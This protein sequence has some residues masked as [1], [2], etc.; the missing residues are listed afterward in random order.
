MSEKQTSTLSI[1]SM[2]SGII[3][4]FFLL[5]AIPAVVCGHLALKEI[6]KENREGRG[7][8]IAGLVTGYFGIALLTIAITMLYLLVIQKT[9]QFKDLGGAEVLQAKE[10]PR[11]QVRKPVI[12]PV[13]KPTIPPK[14]PTDVIITELKKAIRISPNHAGAYFNLGNAYREQDQHDLAIESYK[15]AISI[16]PNSAFAHY[17]LGGVYA[18]QGKSDEAV[19][20]FKA[21]ININPN[22]ESPE[23]QTLINLLQ[24]KRKEVR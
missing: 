13:I 6:K 18:Q 4:I 24:H 9:Q 7:F 16:N 3:G 15:K 12:K 14:I 8:A 10:P 23:L 2:V 22:L 20:S 19:A 5:P 17:N 1:V 11:P 21:A